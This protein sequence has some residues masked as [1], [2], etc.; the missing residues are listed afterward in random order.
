MSNARIQFSTAEEAKWSAINPKLREGELVL[1]K[2]TNGKYKLVV[3]GAGGSN[4]LDS[5]L[6]WDQEAAERLT[7]RCESA[8]DLSKEK[9]REIVNS[10]TAANTANSA[11]QNAM[12][13]AVKAQKAADAAKLA[14][15]AA[16]STAVD[17]AKVA[18]AAQE[19]AQAAQEAAAAARKAAEAALAQVIGG[20]PDGWAEVIA[21]V[22]LFKSMGLYLDAEGCICQK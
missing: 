1:A 15:E 11:A 19:A 3:G 10:A 6:V 18:Q 22:E 12:N 7:E 20:T 8:A 21:A 4:Y 13:E 5:T 17:K 2:K 9:A 16:K 14:A